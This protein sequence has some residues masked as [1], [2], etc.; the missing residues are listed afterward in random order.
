VRSLLRDRLESELVPP[1][2]GEPA[3]AALEALPD[4]DRLCHGD[5]HPANLLRTAERDVVIDWTG[6]S[7]GD[8]AA[9]VARTLIILNAGAVHE[10]APALVKAL[11]RVGRRLLVGGYVRSY[12]RRRAIDTAAVR[13]WLPV[14]GAARLAEGIEEE[15]DD[16]LILLRRPRALV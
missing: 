9:D 6:A 13:R 12:R 7:S 8:P 3:R 5:L 11:E 1:D 15:R 16:L 10:G 2:L 14:V 4:G